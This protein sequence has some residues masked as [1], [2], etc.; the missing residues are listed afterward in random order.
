M[1]SPRLRAVPFAPLLLSVTLLT[2]FS[3]SVSA[4]STAASPAPPAKTQTPS[5][6][7]LKAAYDYKR[8]PNLAVKAETRPDDAGVL[9]HL[10]F[11]NLHG[12]KVTGLFLRPRGN[13]PFPCVLLLHGLN[14]DKE[15]MMRFFGRP[16]AA[17]GIATLALDAGLHG[18]RKDPTRKPDGLAFGQIV[19]GSITEYRLALDYL[20][21]RKEVDSRRVG[22]LGYSMGAIIGSILSGVDERIGATVLCVGGE[23]VRPYFSAIPVALRGLAETI[24]PSNYVGHISPRPVFFINARQDRVISEA[25]AKALQNAAKAPKQVLWVDS[26]HILPESAVERGMVWLTQKLSRTARR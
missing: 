17:K 12:Q 2:G 18:E 9:Q 4:A 13:G 7:V 25:A 23:V 10:T 3:P 6:S 11:N 20:A 21:R 19:G 22:L 16:L 26:G 8:N 1:I 15:V 5:W 14:T 24:S